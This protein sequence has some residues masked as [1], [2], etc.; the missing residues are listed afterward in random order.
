MTKNHEN[1]VWVIVGLIIFVV[2]FGGFGHYGMMGFGISF[3]FLFMLLFW[4][5]IIWL[6]V[7]IIHSAVQKGKVGEDALTILK[8][9]YA[10]GEINKKQ[11]DDMKKNLM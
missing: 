10:K 9:R 11:F 2:L 7:T 1:W 4:A 3:G 6:I 5:A 8:K